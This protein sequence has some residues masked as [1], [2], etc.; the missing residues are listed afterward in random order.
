MS[1]PTRPT[2]SSFRVFAAAALRI[3]LAFTIALLA[4]VRTGAAPL[5]EPIKP[6]AVPTNVSQ[7]KAS[8]GA[9]L[10]YD[11]RLSKNND[12]SCA[13]CHNI[14]SGGADPGKARSVGTAGALGPINAPTVLNAGANFVQLWSGAEPDLAAVVRRVVKGAKLFNT[15]FAEIVNKLQADQALVQRFQTVY[16]SAITENGI[17]DALVNY[18]AAL[19]TPSRFD[20]YLRGDAMALSPEE[21][22]GYERFK[23]LGCIACHQGSNVG[24]NMFQ[25]FGVIQDYLAQRGNLTDA[26]AGRFN[27]TKQDADRGVFRVPSLR[28]VALT[29]PYFHD[30]SAATLAD[31]VDVMIKYQLGRSVSRIDRDALVAF[32][33]SLSADPADLRRL[34]AWATQAPPPTSGAAK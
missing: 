2:S 27:V 4:T 26:D 15:N 1:S 21:R 32:L 25:K 13:S 24:G 20:A 9:A 22:L 14:A 8:L 23:S 10:F 7:A 19:V 3:W 16:G 30:G 28:N 29:P 34:A 12:V 31:A 6:L 17:V 18:Q 33:Q 11:V 5:D